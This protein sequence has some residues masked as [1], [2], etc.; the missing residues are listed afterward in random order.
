MEFSARFIREM[1]RPF[2][3]AQPLRFDSRDTSNP[4]T[5][6]SNNMFSKSLVV[7][8]TGDYI[9]IPSIARTYYENIIR[10]SLINSNVKLERI[11]LPLYTND[12]SQS[13]RT[14]DGIMREFFCKPLLN[15]R[16]LKV[17]TNKG[18]TYY[19]G[20][21]LILDEEFNPL[22]MCGLKARKRISEYGDDTNVVPIQYYRTVCHVSPI[23]FTE[24][25][26]LINKGIIKKLIPLYTT[27]GTTFPNVSVGTSNS[28]DSRK[29]EVIIDDFSKFFISP[30]APTPSKCS[31]EALNKCLNDN[32]EDILYLI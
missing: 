15:Q 21:G 12:N 26:K 17:T 3:D 8:T 14:F 18:D 1:T 32:I 7:D 11:I 13:R 5:L 10:D 22:L 24:P 9:E 19:G 25:N 16:V 23:V 29:V 28:P 6:D 2:Y 31:N 27:M 4:T 20:Y 30:I